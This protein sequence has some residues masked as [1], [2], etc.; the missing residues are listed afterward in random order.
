MSPSRAQ[1][2]LLIGAG[3]FALSALGSQAATPPPLYVTYDANSN[4]SV[5]V[6]GGAA[7]S[8]TSA[9]P[10]GPYWVTF[11][12][13]FSSERIVHKWHLFGPG[14][15][16]STVAADLNCDSSIEQYLGT[17]QPSSVYT[18]QDDFHPA[19]RPVVFRT[20]AT[21][22]S[23]SGQIGV[24]SPVGPNVKNSDPVGS[25]LLPY[26][27]SLAAA[28]SAAGKPSLTRKGRAVSSLKAGRYTI[29]VIDGSAKAGFTLKKV[30]PSTWTAALTGKAFVGKRSVKVQLGAGRW[31][32][33]SGALTRHFVVNT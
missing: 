12:N 10:P 21:G 30:E 17:L 27:G 8:S 31:T 7:L 29:A 24:T 9:I 13:E 32:F 22:S 4:L 19:L 6:A 23:T 26:R 3:F 5:S 15:D 2:A 11:D 33:L 14:V 16:V 1:L 18:V 25:G 20:S 28:V